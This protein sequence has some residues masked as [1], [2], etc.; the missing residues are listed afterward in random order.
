MY[1]YSKLFLKSLFFFFFFFSNYQFYNIVN[2]VRE[3]TLSQIWKVSCNNPHLIWG[4][5][6]DIWSYFFH[7][8]TPWIKQYCFIWSS[9]C[10]TNLV[11][12]VQAIV[13]RYYMCKV[14]K[15][16]NEHFLH[17]I[18]FKVL[19]F[20]Q[21]CVQS[22]RRLTNRRLTHRLHPYHNFHFDA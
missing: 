16:S 9:P 5:I 2:Q 1:C 22:Y 8:N 3:Q 18:Y 11:T 10:S 21:F 12:L 17:D 20:P 19:S 4:S 6:H 14:W 15:L 13:C 7:I